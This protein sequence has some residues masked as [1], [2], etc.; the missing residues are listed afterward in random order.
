MHSSRCGQAQTA[1]LH[2][3]RFPQAGRHRPSGL[4]QPQLDACT[5]CQRNNNQAGRARSQHLAKC[6]FR[7]R[8]VSRFAKNALSLSA[9]FRGNPRSAEVGPMS[10]G[11]V[12]GRTSF[13]GASLP[14]L[15][16]SDPN[17]SGVQCINQSLD[18]IDACAGRNQRIEVCEGKAAFRLS[19]DDHAPYDLWPVHWGRINGDRSS[20][21]Q[22]CPS[23]E[24]PWQAQSLAQSVCNR[25]ITRR[26]RRFDLLHGVDQTH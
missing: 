3:R 15:V 6:D 20:L 25:R 22:G 26:R 17:S 11:N 14:R 8:I 16:V 9:P 23:R 5:C 2:R 18:I 10:C 12:V 24:Q 13:G 4:Q 7:I 21:V 1:V 19:D